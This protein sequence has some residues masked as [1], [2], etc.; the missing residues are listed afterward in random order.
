MAS[1]QPTYTQIFGTTLTE[2]AAEDERIVA[3]TAAMTEGTG[4]KS[5]A[6]AYPE[7]FFDVGIAEAHAVTMA[8]GSSCRLKPVVPIYFHVLTVFMMFVC[9]NCRLFLPSTGPEWGN[10]N[11]HGF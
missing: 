7:R 10:V 1:G 8:G 2:L 9:K 11:H 5:F 6:Q 3:I 4:L